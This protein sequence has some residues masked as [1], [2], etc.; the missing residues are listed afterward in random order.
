[1]FAEKN[2]RDDTNRD[3]DSDGDYIEVVSNCD[4]IQVVSLSPISNTMAVSSA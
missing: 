4:D 2:L 3:E 1:M